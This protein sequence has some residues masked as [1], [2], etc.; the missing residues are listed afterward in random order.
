MFQLHLR[1]T[2]IDRRGR[3]HGRA[4]SSDRVN[5]IM[6]SVRGF[7]RHRVRCGALPSS[8]NALLYEV[9][10]PAGGSM[11]WLEDLP[12][13]VGR[14]VHRLPVGGEGEPLTASIEE[15]V[16]MMAAGG[17]MRDKLLVTVLALTGVRIGQALGLHRSDLHL[18]DNSRAVGCSWQGPHVHAVRRED[19]DNLALSKRRRELVVPAHPWLVSVYAAY[20]VER[21]RVAAAAASDYVFVNLAGGEIGRAMRDGRAREIVAALGRRAGI[22]RTVT[23]HQFRHGLASE[24]SA[25]GRSLDEIQKLLGHA[26]PDTTRR[27]TRTSNQRLR[28]AIE[29]VALPGHGP[30]G[31]P[32]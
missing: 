27:Y 24:L 1:T 20:C 15:Y 13:M 22:E 21:D 5:D 26:H 7:Y 8:V 9:V 32:A 30:A 2:P 14:P 12:A 28:A 6:S 19:N 11:G 17:S 10:E 4:R 3:G 16:A 25:A 29:S 18:M 31:L 23:P